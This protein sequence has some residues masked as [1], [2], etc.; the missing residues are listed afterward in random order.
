[1]ISYKLAK[2]LKDAGFPQKIY[3]FAAVT[4][5][6]KDNIKAAKEGL[7]MP[8]LLELV[9]ACGDETVR[10][11]KYTSRLIDTE[12]ERD[13]QCEAICKNKIGFG[14][15]LEEAVASLYLELNKKA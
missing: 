2:Q 9:E 10:L 12:Y 3:R 14:S 6:D 15:T 13:H 7:R 8:T 4:K 1:M 11:I 5:Q